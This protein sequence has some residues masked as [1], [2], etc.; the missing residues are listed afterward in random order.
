MYE[1]IVNEGT[2]G[3]EWRQRRKTESKFILDVYVE[4]LTKDKIEF[5]V[6]EDGVLMPKESYV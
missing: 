6:Y 5:K 2:D 4:Q 1:I 3:N